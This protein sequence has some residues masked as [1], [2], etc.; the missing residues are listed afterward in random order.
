MERATALVQYI[1]IPRLVFFFAA[2]SLLLVSGCV[3]A[4]YQ[5]GTGRIEQ[6]L[7][8]SPRMDQQYYQGEPNDFLDAS[9]WIWPGSLIGKL[10]LWNT[11]V[12][13]HQISDETI[14][15]L[16]IYIDE[17]DLRNVQVLINCYKPGNQWKRL[18]RN[19]TIHPFWRYTLGIVSVAGYTVLPGR[20]FGGDSYNPYTNTINLYSDNVAVAIHEAGHAKDFGRRELKGTN[21]F[22]YA[23]PLAS[24][25]YEGVAS[26]DALSYFNDKHQTDNLKKGYEILYP[27]YGTYIGGNLAGNA[28]NTALQYVLV[29]PAHIAGRIASWSVDEEEGAVQ[30]QAAEVA[31]EDEQQTDEN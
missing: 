8:D 17:N 31:G 7:L 28:T 15:A 29:I 2:L 25:Y 13:S 14:D 12:D 1:E 16:K 20:F 19:K 18:F 4:P 27:A 11:K 26:S 3:S 5:Y 10:L 23:L 6:D 9:D 21:A 30:E 24:L 22:I